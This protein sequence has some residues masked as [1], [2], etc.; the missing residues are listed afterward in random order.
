MLAFDVAT[1]AGWSMGIDNADA[2]KF[3]IA[4]TWNSLSTNTRMTIDASGNVGIGTATPSFQ[5]HSTGSMFIGNITHASSV[6]PSTVGSAPVTANG[7]RL[8]F[9]NTFNG[10]E[11]TG[12]AA[13]KIVLHNNNWIG[14]F[15]L[16]SSGVT[17]HTGA[18]HNFYI[19]A[20][21]T[22]YGTLALR[23]SSTGNLTTSTS[24]FIG[25]VGHANHAGFAHTST[26]TTTGYALLQNSAG[27]TYLNCASGQAIYFRTNNTD[28]GAFTSTGLGIGTASPSF[29]LDVNGNC[30]ITNELYVGN[31]GGG[32]T[33]FLG[34]GAAGDSG[35]DHSVIETRNYAGSEITELL[36]FKGNDVVGPAGPDRIRLRA[37]AIVFDTHGGSTDRTAESI[38]MVINSSGYVGIGTTAPT[39]PLHI[40]GQ[41]GG[42]S[43]L[44]SDDIAAYSD[45]R[46]KTDIEPITN[47]LEKIDKIAG[48][49]FRRI[50]ENTQRVA[51]VLSQEVQQVLPEVVHEDPDGMLSVAYGN[52]S[53]LLIEAIK[54]LKKEVAD[55]KRV[56]NMA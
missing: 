31:A 45:A 18:G 56:L 4:Q 42:I 17:Y 34:G 38:R 6:I 55:I 19:G 20:T 27:T 12:M 25:N 46:L 44:A 37:G 47:A 50:G 2:D 33:I 26:A 11:G 28:W 29:K 49:T 32:G 5:L 15:G 14:G 21:N 8:V 53:A 10:I 3:K 30:K 39:H 51:G 22:S 24:C 16:E 23:I 35:Y 7:F 41:V 52:M 36:L 40:N 43:I 48:Y 54:E 9:D 1:V 13:N